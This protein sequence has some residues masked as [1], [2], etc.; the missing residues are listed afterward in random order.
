V[1]KIFFFLLLLPSL[2]VAQKTTILKG[3]VKNIQ[4][5]VI[6]IFH[7]PIRSYN[8]FQ[9]KI[10]NGG[11]AYARNNELPQSIGNTW[12][13]LY[14]TYQEEGNLENYVCSHRYSHDRLIKEIGDGRL[15]SDTRLRKFIDNI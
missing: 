13:T 1:K 5:G 10:I 12:R 7:F 3:T 11:A 4:K 6:E 2:L 9:N 15:V 14:K 8:Q